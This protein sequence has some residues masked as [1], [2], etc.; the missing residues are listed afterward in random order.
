M[1]KF[2]IH[3]FISLIG[4]GLISCELE[5]EVFSNITTE[6]F[7]KTPGD[8][9]TALISAYDPI[10]TM[11]SAAVHAVD[12]STDQIYPRPV[13]A[14]DTYTLFTYDP[15]FSAQK[16][17][18]REFESPVQVW[19]SS[20]TGIER[21]NWVLLKVPEITMNE[22]RK[23]AI[24]GEA[25]FLRAFYHWMLTK[26]FG[27][28]IIKTKP[29]TSESEVYNG[30]STIPEVY[31][32]IYSDLDAAMLALP[33]FSQQ[34]PQFGRPS[35]EA[36]MALYAK[37]ALYNKD[38]PKSLQ[39]AESV[40]NAG[41]Y[42][43]LD[44]IEDVFDATKETLARA[45]NIWSF[46]SIRAVPGRTAQVHALFGPPNSAGVEYGN[47][48]FGSAF[49]Y[50]KFYNSF[51]P[52]DDRR[53]LLATSY[54][55][56]S[57]VVVP[58]AGITP[59][60]TEGVL[61]RKFRDPNSIGGAYETNLTIIRMSDVYL[62]AA[63]A[64]AL[65]ANGATAKAYNYINTV[66]RRAKLGDLTPGLTITQFVDA[67]IQERSWE[68]FAEADRWYDLTR[69]GKF[70]TLVP[71]ATNNVFPTRTPQ[72]KHRFFPIPLDEVMANPNLEQN[73]DWN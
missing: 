32:Q 15:N 55:N 19:R 59:I 18:S 41:T 50:Q 71:L 14:R 31:A 64:E 39:M 67:V 28:V 56:R 22:A 35:K 34:V 40:I 62:I 48:S 5:E 16:S 70:L 44:N 66:R 7:F 47:A 72:P 26:N 60:T 23:T 17:F 24:L 4:I 65:A 61:V 49:A 21:A 38:Y 25:H 29:S 9:E 20:Y 30:K 43:L 37:A 53:K 57:G 1:K 42:R 12:F 68:L 51:D 33:S 46:E 45:E 54:I 8:A 69:T 10:A 63:E 36:V 58:Q 27:E 6:N 2:I 73:P 52:A 3:T 13:V 11:Y